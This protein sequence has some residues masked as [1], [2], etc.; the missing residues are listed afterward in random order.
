[1][2]FLDKEVTLELTSDQNLLSTTSVL[3][4]LGLSLQEVTRGRSGNLSIEEGVAVGSS[5]IRSL[6]QNRVSH[7]GN[8]SVNRNDWSIVSGGSQKIASA[9][10]SSCDITSTHLTGID[11]F[12]TNSNSVNQSPV[13]SNL[14]YKLLDLIV[15]TGNVVNT[16]EELKTILLCRSDTIGNLVAVDTVETEER[17]ALKLGSIRKKARLVLAGAICIVG[18]VDDSSLT[19]GGRDFIRSCE[20]SAMTLSYGKLVRAQI[21]MPEF[22]ITYHVAGQS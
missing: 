14:G 3:N 15:T 4:I 21:Q 10:N 6:T 9:V 13:A 18:R 16:K 2:V 1:L 22:A 20:P 8:K 17:E 7:D 11:N 5:I 19:P 12:I